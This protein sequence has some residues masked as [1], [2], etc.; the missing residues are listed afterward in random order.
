MCMFLKFD[1]ID[2]RNNSTKYPFSGNI[3]DDRVQPQSEDTG[4]QVIAI[5]CA[6]GGTV[7]V[8]CDLKSDFCVCMCAFVHGQIHG[9]V[10]AD[11][12]R[13]IEVCGIQSSVQ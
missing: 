9:D 8:S 13:S 5:C 2:V 6:H 7:D 1:H 3:F 11:M 4:N 12:C 10:L